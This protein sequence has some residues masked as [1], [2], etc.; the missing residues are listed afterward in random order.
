MKK[1]QKG[2]DEESTWKAGEDEGGGGYS[3]CTPSMMSHVSVGKTAQTLDSQ[4]N[5]TNSDEPE[6]ERVSLLGGEIGQKWEEG[7]GRGDVTDRRT[8]R[9]SDKRMLD[10]EA[11]MRRIRAEMRVHRQILHGTMTAFSEKVHPIYNVDHGAH[12]FYMDVDYVD[13]QIKQFRENF[14]F[15]D[16]A[17]E[18]KWLKDICDYEGIE[19]PQKLSQNLQTCWRS[20]DM[21]LHCN[22]R[23]SRIY[24]HD[25]NL[26]YD[27][28]ANDF[29]PK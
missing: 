8:E 23:K 27:E 22:Q 17:S 4:P 20:D 2:E 28:N 9:R 10:L 3:R 6:V 19:I 25:C 1:S 18:R 13:S 12:H 16:V 26:R 14:G 21:C 7:R 11:R 15:P 24:N 5:V 29:L